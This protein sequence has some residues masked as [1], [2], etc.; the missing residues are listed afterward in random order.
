MRQLLGL[1]VQD[2]IA[3]GRQLLLHVIEIC[4]VT[5]LNRERDDY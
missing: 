5:Q 1:N 4:S 2:L 3:A